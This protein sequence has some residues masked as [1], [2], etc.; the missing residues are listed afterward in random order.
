MFILW[1]YYWPRK[2]FQTPEDFQKWKTN[3]SQA[4]IFIKAGDEVYQK[5]KQFKLI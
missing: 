3:T 2:R 5:L 1:T 4:E